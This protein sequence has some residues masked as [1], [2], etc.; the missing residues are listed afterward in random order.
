MEFDTANSIAEL[1]DAAKQAES[2]FDHAQLWFR[3]HTNRH[4]NLVPSAF[5]R[6]PV[7][8]SQMANHFRMQAPSMSRNCPQHTDYAS[9]LPFMRHHGVP[10]RLLDW[11]ESVSV[12]AF[13]ATSEEQSSDG[14]VWMLNPGALNRQSIGNL[15]PFLGAD[16]VQPFVNAAFTQTDSPGMAIAVL[17]PRTTPRMATQLGNYTIHGSRN[18]LESTPDCEEFLTAIVIPANAHQ[19][20]GLDLSLLGIRRSTLFP[21]LDNL[22]RQVSDLRAIG[23][24]RE[25]LE[26][27]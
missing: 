19:Q 4:W 20:F 13:F 1:L 25:D 17:A 23:P 10:T 9:W 3:G 8:E 26:E 12:A 7:L 21:D 22:A 5:R 24:D 27:L 16:I 6:H 14:L 18:S 11:T 15:L 2:Q